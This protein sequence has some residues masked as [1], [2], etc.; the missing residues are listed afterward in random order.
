MKDI[1]VYFWRLQMGDILQF[2][3]RLLRPGANY[4]T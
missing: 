3:T 4:R 2:C 1:D